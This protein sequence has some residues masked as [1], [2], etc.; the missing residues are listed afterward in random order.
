MSRTTLLISILVLSFLGLADAIYLAHSALTGSAL[1]CGIT[2]LDGCNVVAQSA[3]SRLFGIPLAVYGVVF[4]TF[5]LALSGL[6]LVVSRRHFYHALFVVAILGIL[7]SIYFIALQIFVIKALCIY[8]LG[9]FLIALLI[10]LCA[11]T[12]YRSHLP[13]HSVPAL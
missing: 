6:L 4:Y 9:S 5:L 2:A 13:R 7:S 12:F 1:A 8:C 10:F 3:Y 11:Y